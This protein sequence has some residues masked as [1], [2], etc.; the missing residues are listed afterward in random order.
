MPIEKITADDLYNFGVCDK[1]IPEPVG[2]ALEREL[3]AGGRL[4]EQACDH[5]SGEEVLLS[6]LF[7]LLGHVQ[8][9][10]NLI[11]GEIPD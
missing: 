10:K 6:V 3:G 7:E 4:E 9:M 8:D 1:I 5:F 2:G 11:F